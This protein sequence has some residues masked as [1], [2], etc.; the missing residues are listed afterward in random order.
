VTEAD[1]RS[2]VEELERERA[3]LIAR[4]NRLVAEAQE[5]AY[6]A[7]RLKGAGVD[8]ERIF[9]SPAGQAAW[10]VAHEARPRI[11]KVRL[12]WRRVVGKLRSML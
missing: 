2:R 8:L 3:E 6:W 12:L 10:R 5:R 11:W 1:L 4:T 9:A 7:D